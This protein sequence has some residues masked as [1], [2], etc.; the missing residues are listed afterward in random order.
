M[1]TTERPAGTMT[2]EQAERWD[3][4]LFDR[5]SHRT[6]DGAPLDRTAAR[7][8][9]ELAP[10]PLNGARVRHVLVEGAE[11][12]AAILTGL[13]GSYGKITGAPAVLLFIG[14]TEDPGHMAAAGY[15]GEQAVLEATS[16]GLATCWV[17]GAFSREQAAR[18]TNLAPGE[19]V[20]AVSPVG[21]PQVGGGLRRWHD[22]S[23][24]TF[25]GS[26][27]RKP[28]EALVQG[29]IGEEWLQHALEA[30][31]WAPSSVN[32]QPWRFVLEPGKVSISHEPSR[33][34]GPY[35][36][37]PRALDCGIAMANFAAGARARG[38]DGAWVF[39]GQPDCLAKFH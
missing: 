37:D 10:E 29:P 7:A 27:R 31:R 32:G 4:V 28:L 8:L 22:L 3:R 35:L 13:V 30:A 9:A 2:R 24:K 1:I 21:L 11:A 36:E 14:Q 23:L 38:V 19:M 39:R 16:L 5:H 15:M 26:T 6:Y 18:H 17:A 20:L 25:A 12:T 33:L 34:K